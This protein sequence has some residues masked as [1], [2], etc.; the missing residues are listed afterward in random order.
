MTTLTEGQHAGGFIVSEAN[1][2]RSREQITLLAN[3]GALVA[4]QVLGKITSGGKYVAVDPDASD[5][6]E[7]AAGILWEGQT[8]GASDSQAVAVV[9][10]AEVNES[11]LT[12]AGLST[13]ETAAAV[14]QLVAL[15]ILMR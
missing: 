10:D 12:F 5:G 7:A 4:G 1:G 11:E 13:A 14:A 2:L 6:S 9:R 8:V 15:G 3:E